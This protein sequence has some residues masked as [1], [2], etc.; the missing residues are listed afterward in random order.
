MGSRS[1]PEAE[2]DRAN[3]GSGVAY[4]IYPGNIYAVERTTVFLDPELLTKA[5]RFARRH[6]KSFAQVVRE[7]VA[8]Y[9]AEEDTMSTRLPS[10]TGRFASG[11]SDTSE[12]VDELLW[13]DPHR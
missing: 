7:A 12:R 3:V 8:S 5:K 6:G 1:V 13:T 2:R 11:R 10:V 4:D 9:V